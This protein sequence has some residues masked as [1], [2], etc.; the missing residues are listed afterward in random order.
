MRILL[1][2]SALLTAGCEFAGIMGSGT[3]VTKDLPLQSFDKIEAGGAIHVDVTQGETYSVSVTA[4]DNL[5]E[6]ADVHIEN[7]TLHLGLKDGSFGNT[8]V[9]A[10][11]VLPHLAG[12]DISG[13]SSATLHG[14]D[15]PKDDLKIQVA[16][17]SKVEGDVATKKL[18]LEVSGASS[19]GLKGRADV[20]AID[21]SGASHAELRD[22]TAGEVHVNASGASEVKINVSGKLDFDVSGASHLS[23]AGQP[24]LHSAQTSGASSVESK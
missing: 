20:L 3:L 15:E 6:Y 11:I 19:A 21:A 23:Y 7:N 12:V 9:S 2:L 4:D 17:A 16:G 1:L 10:K 22:L 14:I 8:H 18:S 5:W 24:V 13:A